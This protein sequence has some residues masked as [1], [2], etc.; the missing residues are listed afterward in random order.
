MAGTPTPGIGDH[1][2]AFELEKFRFREKT[3]ISV[4]FVLAVDPVTKN[5]CGK[6]K[7]WQDGLEP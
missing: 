5:A 6:H 3:F 2:V 1:V 4:I 7:Y